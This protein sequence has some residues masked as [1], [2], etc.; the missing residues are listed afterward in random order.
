MKKKLLT[1]LLCISMIAMLGAC[2]KQED[3]QNSSEA[4]Q[5]SSQSTQT[6]DQETVSTPKIALKDFN[7]EDYVTLGDYVGVT[8]TKQEVIVNDEDVEELVKEIYL[9]SF[10]EDF[11]VTDRAIVVGDTANIDY[12]GKRDGVAFSG[13]TAQGTNLTIGSHTFIDGFEEGLVGVKPGETVDLNLT[14]P[15]NY[16]NDLAGAEVVFTVKVNYIIPEEMMDGP[17]AAY[18]ISGVSTIE[19]LKE[20]AY[21]Y[22]YDTTKT[23]TDSMQEAEIIS[24]FL[25]TCEFKEFPEEL[26]TQYRNTASQS[27][28]DYATSLGATPDVFVQYYYGMDFE[29]FLTQYTTE[30]LQQNIAAQAIANKENLNISD[31]ELD[32]TLM[33]YATSSG[34]SSVEEY[35]GV[36]DKEDFR[37]YFM[38][39][40]VVTYILENA[41][42][43]GDDAQVDD[44]TERSESVEDSAEGSTG[45]AENTEA[46]SSEQ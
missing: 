34:Y 42:I 43:E 15:E 1:G 10:T 17:I 29:T 35:I 5:S 46:S 2:G 25:A 26:V 20:F 9:D 12:E 18:G 41:I 19:E 36:A 27:I 37:E 21:Q 16:G 23:Q 24:N 38:Y 8:V 13:G 40:K 22:L 11:G 45:E 39:E 7:V 6:S 33:E 4:S 44:S 3:N 30:A 31:E 14:F 32:E 28:T